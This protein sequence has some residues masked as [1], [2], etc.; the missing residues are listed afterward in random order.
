M[1]DLQGPVTYLQHLQGC[2]VLVQ[3]RQT[4][5]S[6][7]EGRIGV[8]TAFAFGISEWSAALCMLCSPTEEARN[9]SML[10]LHMQ[11]AIVTFPRSPKPHDSE[12]QDMEW[13]E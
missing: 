10:V 12:Q 3:R 8:Q 1:L 5:S 4:L 7:A 2:S 11:G 9:R 13:P 6:L